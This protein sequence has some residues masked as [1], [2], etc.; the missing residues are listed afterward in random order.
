VTG[1]HPHHSAGHRII[2]P[3]RTLL[4][5]AVLVALVALG[6]KLLSSNHHGNDTD[7]LESASTS[8]APAP[9]AGAPHLGTYVE[10][11]VAA[12]G[13][14][15]VREWIRSTHPI[16]ALRLAT[17][18]ADGKPTSASASDIVVAAQQTGTVL[19]RPGVVGAEVQR[20][21]LGRGAPALYLSYTLSGALSTASS[22]VPGSLL[23]TVVSMD[24]DWS[25]ASGT[26]VRM[27]TGPGSVLDVACIRRS[28]GARQ[29]PRPCGAPVADGWRIDLHGIDR[30][31]RLIASLATG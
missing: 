2:S 17:L 11:T 29:V 20:V 14:V 9:P 4:A 18:G 30:T 25:G 15:Q 3:A 22:T 19:A 5:V 8:A 12:D 27:V 28:N 31:D 24:V 7:P 26:V 13:S 10:S 16:V 1:H 21:S 6:L 23:A